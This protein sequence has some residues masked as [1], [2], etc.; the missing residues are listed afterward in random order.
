MC[1]ASEGTRLACDQTTMAVFKLPF[2]TYFV[3]IVAV[4]RNTASACTEPH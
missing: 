1:A 4:Q 3:T 2:S